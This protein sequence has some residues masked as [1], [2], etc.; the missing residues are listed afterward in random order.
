MLLV[1]YRAVINSDG[2][3]T[4][5]K[6]R[7]AHHETGWRTLSIRLLD[8]VSQKQSG[9]IPNVVPTNVLPEGDVYCGI[10]NVELD[11]IGHPLP[12]LSCI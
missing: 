9:E 1:K 10:A 7:V 12:G 2:H 5:S 11:K 6:I 8:F 3:R 4:Q